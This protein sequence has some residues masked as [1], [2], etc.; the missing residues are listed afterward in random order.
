MARGSTSLPVNQPG[1]YQL[2]VLKPTGWQITSG[3]PE[4]EITFEILPGSVAGLVA[5]KPPHWVGLAPDLT[6]NQLTNDAV[7]SAPQDQALQIVSPQG[8]HH[9]LDPDDQGLTRTTVYPGQWQVLFGNKQRSLTIVDAPV[10]LIVQSSLSAGL[11][12]LPHSVTEN[13]DWLQ[14][15]TID[16]I[17]NNHLSLHWDYL[18]AVHNQEYRGPGYVNGLTSGH[19]VAYNSSGHP[20]T[21]S[22]P[23]GEFFDF[24]G[25]YFSVAWPTAEGEVLNIAAWRESQLVSS[26]RLTLSYLGPTWLEADLRSIDRLTLTTSHYWQFVVDDLTFRLAKPPLD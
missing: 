18:L 20:V 11:T 15:S 12:P 6:L 17:P 21:I 13:F 3:N 7:Q 4:Q 23:E 8:E 5:K 10:A 26:S 14:R 22:A 24:V 2:R 1:A 16:K 9:A 25:G 19:A